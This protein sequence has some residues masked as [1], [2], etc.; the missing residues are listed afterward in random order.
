MTTLPKLLVL[1][2]KAE[3]HEHIKRSFGQYYELAFTTTSTE[4]ADLL[5]RWRVQKQPLTFFAAVFANEQ[6]SIVQKVV[7]EGASKKKNAQSPEQDSILTLFKNAAVCGVARI[8]AF[9]YSEDFS[10]QRLR[11]LQNEEIL[12]IKLVHLRRRINLV[13]VGDSPDV[14]VL[15]A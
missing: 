5:D 10:M 12:R 15:S 6:W 1:E 8:Y 14:E 11:Q 9:K 13:L 4:A 3:N 2:P 7:E